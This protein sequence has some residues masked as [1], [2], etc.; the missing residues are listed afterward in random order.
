MVGTIAGHTEFLLDDTLRSWEVQG[1][2][3][4]M[5]VE[6]NRVVIYFEDTPKDF[7]AAT[8]NVVYANGD[9]GVYKFIQN[10]HISD[11]IRGFALPLS[12]WLKSGEN[13][14]MVFRANEVTE[15]RYYVNGGDYQYP[16]LEFVWKTSYDTGVVEWMMPLSISSS[17][18]YYNVSFLMNNDSQGRFDFYFY[19]ESGEITVN[20]SDGGE[21]TDDTIY[22]RQANVKQTYYLDNSVPNYNNVVKISRGYDTRAGGG[23]YMFLGQYIKGSSTGLSIEVNG[24]T[25]TPDEYDIVFPYHYSAES[26]Y[27]Q[28]SSIKVIKSGSIKVYGNDIYDNADDNDYNGY[29]SPNQVQYVT[30]DYKFPVGYEK[31]GIAFDASSC[32]AM[33]GY[34]LRYVNEPRQVDV[35]YIGDTCR[36]TWE[37]DTTVYDDVTIG[38]NSTETLNF[39]LPDHYVSTT[40]DF[41]YVVHAFD[42]DFPNEVTEG[43]SVPFT[44]TYPIGSEITIDAP[45]GVDV[46][47]TSIN[48]GDTHVVMTGMITVDEDYLEETATVVISD[49]LTTQKHTIIVLSKQINMPEIIIEY[50]GLT[51]LPQSGNAFSVKVTYTNTTKERINFPLAG[52]YGVTMGELSVGSGETSVTVIYSVTV[53]NNYHARTIP[54]VFSC[55]NSEGSSC[56]EALILS[57]EGEEGTD[58]AYIHLNHLYYIFPPEGG[59]F[60]TS[61]D[62]LYPSANYGVSA[63]VR[64]YNGV[65]PIRWCTATLRGSSIDDDGWQGHEDWLIDMTENTSSEPRVAEVEFSYTS[66]YGETATATFMA[67]IEAGDTEPESFEPEIQ[68]YNTILYLTA[69]GKNEYQPSLDYV[70]VNYQDFQTGT[71]N[72][73]VSNAGW[74]RITE[75]VEERRDVDGIL[76]RYYYV[77]DENTMQQP[78]QTTLSLIA[79][80]SGSQYSTSIPIVQARVEGD[81][82]DDDGGDTPTP[83]IPSIEGVYI[84]QI[85]RD[86]EFNF[87]NIDPVSYTIWYG[88]DMIFAGRSWKRP[89]E[90]SNKILINKICQDYMAQ[91]PIDLIK[92]GWEVS[93]KDFT[94]RDSAGNEIYA[95]YRFINDWSY[96]DDFKDGLLSHPILNRQRAV[97]GQLFPFSLFGAGEQV[98]VEYGI[99]YRDGYTDK[100]GNPIEDWWST[101]YITNGVST[102]YFLKA[103]YDAEEIENVWIG[104]HTYTIEEP[105]AI[106]YV[107]YYLNPWGGYDWF[108]VAGRVTKSDSI[109]QYTVQKNYLNTSLEFG[110][111]RYL[112]EIDRDF[113]INSG[114]LKQEESDRMWYLIES[115]VVYLHDINANKIMPVIITD[116]Q[117]QHKQKTS[118]DKIINYTFHVQMSQQMERI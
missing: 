7:N 13:A 38:N 76:M 90:T 61:L 80:V 9:A 68:P 25:F 22:F 47:T 29:L 64:N 55:S 86:V 91:V 43:E 53:N 51:T 101:E 89:G 79:Y 44:V 60:G 41:R 62:Y 99:N 50:N 42:T 3:I 6:G 82:D 49:G 5:T 83:D 48:T 112:S 23:S 77:A 72:E 94:L 18:D 78:R 84:G 54:L 92:T 102:E 2:N 74:F 100:F 63:K 113:E 1:D 93:N 98:S 58:N 21:Y 116:T 11:N 104:N 75:I 71:I 97:R 107:L 46:F 87:G 117:M 37:I 39:Y 118:K 96:S 20:S 40:V 30:V 65:Y 56:T 70:Q 109:R 85:W 115:N 88:D 33:F 67:I 73:P 17:N 36:V 10:S 81:D 108:P 31:Q 16:A 34:N 106:K 103:Y 66:N 8:I 24:D 69:E 110:K 32:N 26:K 15:I 59:S 4:T 57:Q 45:E 27:Y 14:E 111:T 95:T 114:W 12:T 52:S 28:T 19:E 35:E 105:C